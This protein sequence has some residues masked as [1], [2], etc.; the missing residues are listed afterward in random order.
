MRLGVNTRKIFQCCYTNSGV[1]CSDWLCAYLLDHLAKI[2]TISCRRVANKNRID[3]RSRSNF[4]SKGNR[5]RCVPLLL[6]V[7]LLYWQEKSGLP[8]HTLICYKTISLSGSMECTPVGS[9]PQASVCLHHWLQS[10]KVE[11]YWFCHKD[12]VSSLRKEEERDPLEA[13]SIGAHQRKEIRITR[14]SLPRTRKHLKSYDTKRKR[15]ED[16][17]GQKEIFGSRFVATIRKEQKVFFPKSISSQSFNY[18]T[19]A[20]WSESQAN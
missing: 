8:R 14:G 4:I 17:P 12:W 9:R 2:T 5:L 13:T 7:C 3:I 6:C 15:E 20:V 16:Y 11:T 19:F 1:R 18:F 10:K